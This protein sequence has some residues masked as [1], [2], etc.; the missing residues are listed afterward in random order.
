MDKID[1]KRAITLNELFDMNVEPKTPV[2]ED[3]LY[4][5]TY[6]FAGAPKVGKSFFMAQL[7]Y[8]VATGLPLWGNK[9]YPSTV[10]YLALEDTYSRLQVRL[11]C[12]F[13]V[14]G[15]DR[16]F[17]KTRSCTFENGLIQELEDFLREHPDTRFVIIDTLQKVRGHCKEFN[18]G[19]DYEVV[20]TLKEFSDKHNICLLVVHHTRKMESSDSF[21]MIS[22]TAGLLG[23]ADGAFV[24]LKKERTDKEAL[25]DVTGRDQPDM[26]FKMEFDEE[27]HVWNL[28][29]LE[30][31][32]WRKPVDPVL[33]AVN[34]FLSGDL[35][36]WQGTAT[37]LLTLLPSQSLTPN[38]LTRRLNTGKG[39]LWDKYGIWYE[40]K[41]QRER[42]I[43]LRRIPQDEQ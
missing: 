13:G 5:G 38:V 2:V 31:E 17:L 16:L 40:S 23:A 42:K 33:E 21:E 25:M 26:R 11:S 7:G 34:D 43:Y 29:K 27:R 28:A 8:H 9:V 15:T 3:M 4:S 36:Q 10:L 20:T 18:Y 41:H 1:E 37:E 6:L 32:L 19:S 24:V 22:G 30:R 14:T 39:T 35:V 12:M